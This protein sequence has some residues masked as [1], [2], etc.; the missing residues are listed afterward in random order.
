MDSCGAMAHRAVLLKELGLAQRGAAAEL[1]VVVIAEHGSCAGRSA[2]GGSNGKRLQALVNRR[3]GV[4]SKTKAVT[5]TAT[6]C[7]SEKQRLL[8]PLRK[9]EF[10]VSLCF[11]SR[12]LSWHFTTPFGPH[13]VPPLC[14]P[15]AQSPDCRPLPRRRR[16]CKRPHVVA[17]RPKKS[18]ERGRRLCRISPRRGRAAQPSGRRGRCGCLVVC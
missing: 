16:Y 12:H 3:V 10:E 1:R 17:L 11:S 18:N 4:P 9:N 2:G 6:F 8:K 15:S 5:E 13:R 7:D 14:L